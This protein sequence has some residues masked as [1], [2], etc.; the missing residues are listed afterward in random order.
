MADHSSA[1]D[2]SQVHPLIL[3]LRAAVSLRR[4]LRDSDVEEIEK[5]LAAASNPVIQDLQD[6]AAK[7]QHYL[8]DTHTPLPAEVFTQLP[9]E[10]QN[11]LVTLQG[12]ADAPMRI[13]SLDAKEAVAFVTRAL[14]NATSGTASY[15]PVALDAHGL[16]AIDWSIRDL[17]N[18]LEHASDYDLDDI[19]QQSLTTAI[20][21]MELRKRWKAAPVANA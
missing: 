18:I 4:P 9:P 1:E 19:T 17:K 2:L 20:E 14:L 13:H 5:A 12:L 8:R 21:T 10:A 15:E 7:L 3:D 16:R 11:A 6:M